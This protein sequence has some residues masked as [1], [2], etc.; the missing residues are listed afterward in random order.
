[1]SNTERFRK[2]VEAHIALLEGAHAAW[3]L[4]KDGMNHL[5]DILTNPATAKSREEAQALAA[6]VLHW[7]APEIPSINKSIELYRKALRITEEAEAEAD[8]AYVVIDENAATIT[9]LQAAV[10]ELQR[11][12]AVGVL[13]RHLATTAPVVTSTIEHRAI[14][15][16]LAGGHGRKV[17]IRC[18]IESCQRPYPDGIVDSTLK[19]EGV[20]WE[21][22][23]GV[24]VSPKHVHG[25]TGRARTIDEAFSV[26]LAWLKESVNP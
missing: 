20:Y 6:Q 23:A 8:A 16:W 21:V 22:L 26:S 4:R 17:E 11:R 15:E 25:M 7:E 5:A 19:D 18:V 24:Y 3:R 2:T 1:M 10:G 12:A 13:Q 14:A 9:M